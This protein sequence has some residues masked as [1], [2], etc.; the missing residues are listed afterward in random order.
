MEEIQ[1]G[2]VLVK[3]V[4]AQIPNSVASITSLLFVGL[5]KAQRT[6]ISGKFPSLLTQLVPPLAVYQTEVT[7]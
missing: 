6:G 5:N 3:V 7:P 4:V 2:E 1:V